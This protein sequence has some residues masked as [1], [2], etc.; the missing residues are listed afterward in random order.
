[1]RPRY[2]MAP[3]CQLAVISQQIEH[4]ICDQGVAGSNIPLREFEHRVVG[5]G[6]NL[7]LDGEISE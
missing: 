5:R 2:G 7:M 6:S 1:M 3:R 4:L